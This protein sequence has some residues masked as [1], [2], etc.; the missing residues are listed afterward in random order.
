MPGSPIAII[1][2][3]KLLV[4]GEIQV[5]GH[6]PT[7]TAIV[8]APIVMA[9]RVVSCGIYLVAAAAITVPLQ[10]AI[11]QV[12]VLHPVQAA[13]LP[14]LLHQEAAAVHRLEDFKF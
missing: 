13:A 7:L 10:E 14:V 9:T 4:A 3:L 12:V 6:I 1:Q 8:I 2:T 11:I 5:Q